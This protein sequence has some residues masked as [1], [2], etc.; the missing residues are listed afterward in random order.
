M[1]ADHQPPTDTVD[2]LRRENRLLRDKL[3]EALVEIEAVRHGIEA[4]HD[5]GIYNYRHPLENAVAYQQT[6][7]EISAEMKSR[8]AEG[9]AIEVSTRFTFDNSLAKGR[10]I[11]PPTQWATSSSM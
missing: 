11:T 9:T 8:I 7:A 4:L 10:K 3:D 5:V 6:L 1:S 2:V